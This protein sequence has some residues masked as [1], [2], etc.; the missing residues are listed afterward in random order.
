MI[1]RILLAFLF[2][3]SSPS[4]AT[5]SAT[6]TSAFEYDSSSGLLVKEIIEPDSSSLCLVTTY[7]YDAYGNKIAA[8]TRNCNGSSGEAAAPAPASTP[9]FTAR[10]SS[11]SFIAT[12]ANPVAGQFPTSSTNALSQT[13]TKEFDAKFG[14]VTRLTGPNGLVTTWTYDGFGRKTSESRA[15]GTSTS[16]AYTICG[17]CPTGGKYFITETSTGA[18]VKNVYYDSLNRE[19]RSE[20]QG[21]DGTY[22]RKDTQYDGLGR[23]AQVSKPY[24][25]GATAVWTVYT[26]DI[27][28]RVTQA[29]E[30][31]T[32]SGAVRTATAYN[33]LET[34]VTVSNAGSGSNLPGGV[35][36]SSTT[37]KNSQGQVIQVV[38]Q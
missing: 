37:T 8:T 4:L 35:T 14:T 7:T 9:V 27:L 11:S 19:I 16:W 24:L 26:Y 6:R 22:V 15:D 23:L 34:T 25:A 28:G 30:P 18:P 36:Q 29:D 20:V 31:S 33:G 2:A 10:T 12:T 17:T 32:A 38:R 1:R 5:S 3:V 21:F 13:E